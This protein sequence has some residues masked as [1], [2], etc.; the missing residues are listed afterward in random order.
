MKIFLLDNTLLAPRAM[1]FT[2][3]AGVPS[4]FLILCVNFK[5]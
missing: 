3:N 1:V 5:F 4:L 2:E